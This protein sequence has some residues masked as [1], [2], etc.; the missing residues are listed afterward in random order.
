V[1]H[2]AVVV[3]EALVPS[4]DGGWAVES[5][6]VEGVELRRLLRA[7]PMEVGPALA[8][9][10]E[11][12]EALE[13]AWTATDAR[14]RPLLLTH[15]ALGIDQVMVDLSGQ[16]QILRMGVERAVRGTADPAAD[17]ADD[18]YHLAAIFFHLVTGEA[19]GPPS[20]EATAHAR[21]VQA[22]KAV[23]AEAFVPE[24]V[25]ELVGRMLAFEPAFRPRHAE[26]IAGLRAPLPGIPV[27]EVPEEEPQPEEIIVRV[28]LRPGW[29][30]VL[31]VLF[32]LVV[33]GMRGMVP[34]GF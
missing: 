28:A 17:S 19:F 8:M 6:R 27:A 21:R 5:A 32:G 9:T 16:V 29:A 4:P 31:G 2:P 3:P 7:G 34:A 20:P 30:V 12:A 24:A 14:G 33:L 11:L 22:A 26:C 23:L 15:G 18:V 1:L 13:Y 25:R 10:A